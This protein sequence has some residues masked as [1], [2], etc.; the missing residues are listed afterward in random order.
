MEQFTQQLPSLIDQLF[1]LIGAVIA[2]AVD[3]GAGLC[4]IFIH[5]LDHLRRFWK[6]GTGI[7][8]IYF[9]VSNL[10]VDKFSITIFKKYVKFIKQKMFAMITI[11]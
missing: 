9:F 10:F 6:G 7:I 1:H 3:I 8:Q 2:P 4:H 11:I 5:C